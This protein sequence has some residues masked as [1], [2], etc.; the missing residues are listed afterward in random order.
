MEIE[1]TGWR[2][3]FLYQGRRK[4]LD[5]HH[6]GKLNNYRCFRDKKNIIEIVGLKYT[7]TQADMRLNA[8]KNDLIE[9]LLCSTMIKD[10]AHLCLFTFDLEAVGGG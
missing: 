2:S 10:E 6:I 7:K 5:V 3:Y 4:N 8:I 9:I 1:W